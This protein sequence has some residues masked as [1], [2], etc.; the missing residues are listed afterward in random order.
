M[1]LCGGGIVGTRDLVGTRD[2]SRQGQAASLVI[3]AVGTRADL[4]AY[5]ASRSYGN[6]MAIN[7]VPWCWGVGMLKGGVEMGQPIGLKDVKPWLI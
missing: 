6:N 5:P 1:W 7:E 3:I 4:P 2:W